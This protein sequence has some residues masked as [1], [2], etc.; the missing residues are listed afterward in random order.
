[1]RLA[2]VL[3]LSLVISGCAIV[4]KDK[5][6][7]VESPPSRSRAEP[8]LKP[9]EVMRPD[10]TGIASPVSDHFAFRVIYFQPSVTTEVRLDPTN[11]LNDGTLLSA[12]E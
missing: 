5:E 4:R 12:E 10:S 9:S 8:V 7:P 3:V 6:E 2:L 11:G 1:M